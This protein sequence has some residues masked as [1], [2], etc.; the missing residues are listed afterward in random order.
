MKS[1]KSCLTVSDHT[2]YIQCTGALMPRKPL[3]IQG[4]RASSK[5]C[6]T[7]M[8]RFKSD[9]RLVRKPRI[10]WISGESG[11]FL[12]PSIFREIPPFFAVF[13]T[14]QCTYNV[15][16]VFCRVKNNKNTMYEKTLESRG[17]TAFV[18]LLDF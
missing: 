7:L 9:C 18:P 14:I 4:S 6:N 17:I 2:M 12:L 10:C 15:R 5:A 13:H 1:S 3:Q 8:H 16:Y 11:F